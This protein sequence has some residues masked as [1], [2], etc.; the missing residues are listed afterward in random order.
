MTPEAFDTQ[1][2]Y[3]KNYYVNF[4][5][6]V[7]RRLAYRID[8]AFYGIPDPGFL[9]STPKGLDALT[10]DQV[11]AAIKKYLRSNNM[12]AVFIA[13]DAEGLKQKLLSGAPTPITY[14]GKQP[15][16]ILEED[17]IIASWPVPVKETDITVLK[18]DNVFE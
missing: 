11:N 12:W 10:R 14:A 2:G 6:T 9:A 18:I 17:K 8:D 1:R 13:Q 16:E 7:G 5:N 3:L 4:G 15:Q